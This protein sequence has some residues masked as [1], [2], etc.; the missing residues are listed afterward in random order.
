MPIK[1]STH[2]YTQEGKP[3]YTV[4][5]KN[6]KERN[7]NLRDA[8][9]RNLVPSV[10]TIMGMAAK[11]G[12]VNWQIDQALLAALTLPKVEGESLDQFKSRAKQDAREQVSQSA[13]RG[14]EIHAIIEGYYSGDLRRPTVSEAQM[15][16]DL[17]VT[18]SQY[19]GGWVAED[20]FCNHGYGG[21]ID[22]YGRNVF[23]DFKSK[24]G[25][26]GK[27]AKKLAF[28]ENGMQLSA[29]AHGMNIDDPV[30]ISVFIDRETLEVK[31]YVWPEESHRRHL[32]M[33]LALKQ[34]WYLSK[35]LEQ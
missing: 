25:I 7:T 23:V 9:E 1:E 5:G 4:I 18:L 32:G 33:F 10:T 24:D 30:R 21:K 27:D 6:G 3:Q 22:L 13:K 12:L 26:A 31:Y 16:A 29:Y 17:D 15:L 11:P 35:N 14:T 8:R 28:D 20:S 19:G 2:W 34:F